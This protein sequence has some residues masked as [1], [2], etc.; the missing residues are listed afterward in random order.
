MS[1]MVSDFALSLSPLTLN[2]NRSIKR[3]IGHLCRDERQKPK[4]QSELQE[5]HDEAPNVDMLPVEALPTPLAG[6][7]SRSFNVLSISHFVLISQRAISASTRHTT[8]MATFCS[9]SGTLSL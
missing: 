2:S 5:T 3:E 9:E 1:E 4:G 8:T 7:L 6:W